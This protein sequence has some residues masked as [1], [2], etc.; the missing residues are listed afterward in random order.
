MVLMNACVFK[1]H[2]DL[3]VNIKVIQEYGVNGVNGVTV[4]MK[5]DNILYVV[6]VFIIQKELVL[7]PV[8]VLQ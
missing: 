4:W 5:K 2:M 7:V 8:L 6:E 3:I 1:A